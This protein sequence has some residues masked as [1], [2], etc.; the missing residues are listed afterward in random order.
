MRPSRHPYEGRKMTP[1]K[2]SINIQSQHRFKGHQRLQRSKFGALPAVCKEYGKMATA[3][4]QYKTS[5]G[6][7]GQDAKFVRKICSHRFVGL[8][9]PVQ[10]SIAATKKDTTCPLHGLLEQVNVVHVWAHGSKVYAA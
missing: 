6:P 9:I 3:A 1:A 8:T 4:E 7:Y 10:S 2:T 5:D